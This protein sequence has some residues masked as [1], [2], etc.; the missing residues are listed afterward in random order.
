MAVVNADD[1]A[2]EGLQQ[3]FTGRRVAFSRLRPVN[4]LYLKDGLMVSTLTEGPGVIADIKALVGSAVHHQEN[5]LAAACLAVLCGVEPVV[6]ERGIKAFRGLPHR[7]QTIAAIAGVSFVNDSKSTTVASGIRAIETMPG[8]VVLIAGGRDKGSDFGQLRPYA[9]KLKAAV[10]IGEDGWKIGEAL[11]GVV[12]LHAA[13]SLESAVRKAFD[14]AQT[15]EVVLLSPMCTS[16]DM[17]G[18]FEQRGEK[19]EEIVRSLLKDERGG[20]NSKEFHRPPSLP[21]GQEGITH[22]LSRTAGP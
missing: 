17:F 11:K 16:F 10:L 13:D 22:H 7:Q 20:L 4:G 5:A 2:C 18:S 3:Q 21:I 12:A 15:P 8:K 6:I 1:P 19:F 9:D 14:L